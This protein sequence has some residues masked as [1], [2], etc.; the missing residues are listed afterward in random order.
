MSLPPAPPSLGSPGDGLFA[1]YFCANAHCVRKSSG[2]WVS[3][4]SCMSTDGS[5][6]LYGYMDH[7][8]PASTFGII[9]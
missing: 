3:G 5:N 4:L 2:K 9:H 8:E 1:D 7:A 6:G